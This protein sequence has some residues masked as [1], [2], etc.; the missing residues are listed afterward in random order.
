MLFVV[1]GSGMFQAA[2]AGISPR[3]VFFSIV[4]WSQMLRI[5]AVMDQKELLAFLNPDRGMCK[6]CIAGFTPRS[7]F[8][9]VVGRPAGRSV[10]TRRTIVCLACFA[11]EDAPRAVLLFF[12]V[13]PKMLGI[14]AS[15]TQVNRCLEEYLK[16]GF[17]WE[18][19]SYVSLFCSLVR[20]WIHIHVSLQ[21]PVSCTELQKTAE[22]PQLQFLIGHRHLFRGAEAVSHGPDRS[23]DHRDFA[24]AEFGDRCPCCA[25]RAGSRNSQLQFIMVVYT[26]VVAQSLSHGP[27][28]SSDH[29]DLYL[30]VD[31]VVDALVMLVVRVP[32]HL[33]PCR[34]A[35]SWS[36]GP[37]C[38]S[39]HEIPQLLH[40]VVD[41]LVVLVEQV[42]FL[43]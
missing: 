4:A 7:V 15:M 24:A 30:L 11:G 25:G 18:M 13:R 16:I 22:F 17:F 36:H 6:A 41:A 40:I 21:R 5:T 3:A 23:S 12:V 39:D 19:T 14:M 42:H 10:W 9:L 32:G 20:Q 29:R 37:D 38:S 43:S 34:G 26:P 35:D 1:S 8:P 31:K 27:D 2:F 28:S 33:H